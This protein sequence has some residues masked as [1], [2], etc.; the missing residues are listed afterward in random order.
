MIVTTPA[1]TAPPAL[2]ALLDRVTRGRGDK[3]IRFG[4]VSVVGILVTQVVLIFCHGILDLGALLSNL[5]AVTVAAVP[6]FVLN[7]RWVWG[8]GGRPSM[9]FEVLPFWGFT[10][11]G[12]VV[13]TVMVALA[14]SFSDSTVLLMAANI[15][16]F[17]LVWLSKFLFLDSVVFAAAEARAAEAGQA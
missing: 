16:G 1:P 12:L 17:G 8:Q 2:T 4:M 11:L 7:K 6:V 10:L 14:S 5:I 3:L 13:S 15:G 9:R